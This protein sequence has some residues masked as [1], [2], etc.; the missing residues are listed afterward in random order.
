MISSVSEENEFITDLDLDQDKSVDYSGMCSQASTSTQ[1]KLL[2]LSQEVGVNDVMDISNNKSI[3]KVKRKNPERI[4][5]ENNAVLKQ[6]CN[7]IDTDS[8]LCD[9]FHQEFVTLSNKYIKLM[10]NKH[11]K[12]ELDQHTVSSHNI[13][14]RREVCRRYKST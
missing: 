6:T 13:L 12:K 5:S 1:A 10:K 3:K 14:D 11:S 7:I 8:I 4:Y 9:E 2:Q